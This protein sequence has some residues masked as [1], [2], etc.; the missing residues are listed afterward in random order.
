MSDAIYRTQVRFP[1]ALSQ[2]LKDIAWHRK[3]SFNT[4]LI[5]ILEKEVS[6]SQSVREDALK[7]QLADIQ[8]KLS[9]LK[10]EKDNS[11][12]AA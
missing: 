1:K 7:E 10:S 6:D 9:Q 8:Q 2:K 5:E 4:L 12:E 3:T 11:E